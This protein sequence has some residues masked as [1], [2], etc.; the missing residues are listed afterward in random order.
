[1]NDELDGVENTR[2]L[3]W[4]SFDGMQ[5]RASP[6]LRTWYIVIRL[7][8]EGFRNHVLHC[9]PNEAETEESRR[10]YYLWYD[11]DYWDIGLVRCY[12]VFSNLVVITQNISFFLSKP[13]HPGH[14]PTKCSV[15]VSVKLYQLVCHNNDDNI[16]LQTTKNQLSELSV[17]SVSSRQPPDHRV[18]SKAVRKIWNQ[19]SIYQV[20]KSS[21]N[22]STCLH[23]NFST[24]Q[25]CQQLFYGMSP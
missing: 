5:R 16:K 15:A 10:K 14:P 20:F 4:W 1:M 9:S 2:H 12:S 7:R 8:V 17:S 18:N 13:S 22:V 23:V 6:K 21:V 25:Q 19:E 24:R 3:L 11:T